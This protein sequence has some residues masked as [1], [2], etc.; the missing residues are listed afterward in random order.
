[1][2]RTLVKL[3]VVSEGAWNASVLRDARSVTIEGDA[4]IYR[5]AGRQTLGRVTF[6]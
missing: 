1:M 5:N 2:Q 6:K 4:V 3:R